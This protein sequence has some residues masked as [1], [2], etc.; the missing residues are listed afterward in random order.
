MSKKAHVLIVDCEVNMCWALEDILILEGYKTYSATTGKEGLNLINLLHPN[1]SMLFLDAKLSDID[2][3]RFASLAKQRHPQIKII[4]L[5]GNY[6]SKA[7][8]Q[9]FANNYFFDGFISKPFNV[10]EIRSAIKT[11]APSQ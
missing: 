8:R 10:S 2:C 11:I 1:I 3:M 6:D 4:I 9:G 5:S 7:V